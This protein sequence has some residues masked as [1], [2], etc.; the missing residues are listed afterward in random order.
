MLLDI[1]LERLSGSFCLL[2]LFSL[3]GEGSLKLAVVLALCKESNIDLG[4][5]F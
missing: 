1:F 3:S 2:G 5:E 4:F